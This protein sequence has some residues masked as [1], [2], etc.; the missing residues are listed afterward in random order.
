M[1]KTGTV[2]AKAHL[3]GKTPT[4]TK[5]VVISSPAQAPM[6]PPPPADVLSS[7]TI[8]Y[9]HYKE[10]FPTKN[11][12]MLWE[13]IDEKFCL[14]FVFKGDFKVILVGSDKTRIPMNAK[15]EFEGIYVSYF[16]LFFGSFS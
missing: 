8:T 12:V 11:A 6:Q 13:V 10:T 3:K 4:N 14:T 16:T 9:N 1:L 5:N 15:M 7:N 2:A